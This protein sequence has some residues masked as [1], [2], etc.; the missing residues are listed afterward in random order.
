MVHT[1]G[2]QIATVAV[3]Q[4]QEAVAGPASM[5]AAVVGGVLEIAVERGHLRT[6]GEAV[7][8]GQEHDM[9]VGVT[10]KVGIEVDFVREPAASA[11]A[12]VQQHRS[13]TLRLGRLSL[14]LMVR[15]LLLA[16]T[17]VPRGVFLAAAM[18][19]ELDGFELGL[20]MARL[21]QRLANSHFFA[22]AG[23]IG[24][25]LHLHLSGSASRILASPE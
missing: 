2:L 16:V 20:H 6:A 9:F 25:G 4:L 14:V 18:D 8:V 3:E 5:E 15:N 23:D 7:A 13:N 12:A 17:V 21:F 19:F 10:G 22:A 1:L 11:G 24:Y